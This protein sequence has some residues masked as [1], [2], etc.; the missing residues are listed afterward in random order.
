[1]HFRVALAVL[2]LDRTRRMNDRRIDHRALAQ[3]QA[4]VTQIAV[5]DLQDPA[6]QLMFLQQAPEVEDRGFIGN[7]IQMQPRELAKDIC[8]IGAQPFDSCEAGISPNRE[9]F[10]RA[11]QGHVNKKRPKNPY[12]ISYSHLNSREMPIASRI[13]NLRK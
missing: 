2:V 5:D 13:A 10:F 1:M 7:S 11:S 4:T 3:H 6:R 8:F 12:E 9:V